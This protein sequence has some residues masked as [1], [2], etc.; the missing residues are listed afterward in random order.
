L[1][2]NPS[3][4]EQTVSSASDSDLSEFQA[5]VDKSVDQAERHLQVPAGTI[6]SIQGDPD[7]IATLKTYAVIESILN[8]LIGQRPPFFGMPAPELEDKY[9]SFVA[10]LSMEGRAGKLALAEG[11]GLLAPNEIDF[12]RAVTQ[13]RNRYA[14]NVK[15][16]HRSLAEILLEVQQKHGTIVQNLTG[17]TLPL[18]GSSAFL[19][20]LGMYFRLA[21][22]LAKALHTL[23]PPPPPAGRGLLDALFT[24]PPSLNATDA[25]TVPS[26]RP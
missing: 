16:M 6:S 17:I 13:V 24:L 26:P 9:R 7:F 25:E 21:S 20:K 3:G 10:A 11:L 22:Y 1:S 15:N 14:H 5:Q 8:D 23:R 18:A 19:L 12:V 4:Q 2:G